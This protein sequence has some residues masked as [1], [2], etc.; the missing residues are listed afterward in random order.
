MRILLV[1]LLAMALWIQTVWDSEV[2]KYTMQVIVHAII[3]VHRYPLQP[4]SCSLSFHHFDSSLNSDKRII[5]IF[6]CLVL[7]CM[8]LFFYLKK[9][10]WRMYSFFF[11]SFI[12]R[13]IDWFIYLLTFPWFIYLLTLPWFIHLFIHSFIHSFIFL[14]IYSFTYSFIDLFIFSFICLFIHW[15][16]CLLIHSLIYLFGYFF[17]SS[18]IHYFFTHLFN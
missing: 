18:F 4:G 6:F 2:P 12:D 8:Y 10:L 3:L 15:S 7:Y 16:I 9:D 13:W 5:R 11:N 17:M 1:L 14:F